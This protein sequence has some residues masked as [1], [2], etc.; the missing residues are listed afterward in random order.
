MPSCASST[1]NART[2]RYELAPPTPRSRLTRSQ[3]LQA[4]ASRRSES[5]SKGGGQ[6]KQDFF[7]RL[8]SQRSK[9]FGVRLFGLNHDRNS[10][11]F[12]RP[13]RSRPSAATRAASASASLRLAVSS[14]SRAAFACTFARSA[15]AVARAASSFTRCRAAFAR[16]ASAV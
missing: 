3:R 16:S 11:P 9:D 5:V 8:C 6:K 14:D 13:A 1:P 15:S 10:V 4:D 2:R 12:R 7:A